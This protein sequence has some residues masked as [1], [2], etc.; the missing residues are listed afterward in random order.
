M[1]SVASKTSNRIELRVVH[2]LTTA[3]DA[4]I[5][6]SNEG[7]VISCPVRTQ[8]GAPLSVIVGDDTISL[9]HGKLFIYDGGH[10]SQPAKSTKKKLTYGL[11]HYLAN[12]E[13]DLETQEQ[14]HV[15][16][17]LPT[18]SYN[19]IWG[20]GSRGNLP[21]LIQL[22]VKGLREDSRWDIADIGAMLLVEDFSFSFP[23]DIHGMYGPA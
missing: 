7:Q 10:A 14:F 9:R 17:Y 23:I 20:L 13:V 5:T 12:I 3:L 19:T 16:L 2:S 1:E 22:Q 18:E 4:W 8:L 6:V 11:V 21:R 15:K